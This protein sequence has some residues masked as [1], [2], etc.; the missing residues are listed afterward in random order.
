MKNF[1]IEKYFRQMKIGEIFCENNNR[2]FLNLKNYLL[3]NECIQPLANGKWKKIA[4]APKEKPVKHVKGPKLW[5]HQ[6]MKER[7][8]KRIKGE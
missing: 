7:I 2:S 4:E 8:R 6:S 1:W 5:G 3:K